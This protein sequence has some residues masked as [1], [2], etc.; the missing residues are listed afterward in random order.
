MSIKSNWSIESFRT[1][2]AIFI[3]C[4]EDLP[5]D[6]SGVLKSPII[7]VLLSISP[8]VYV[9]ICFTYS[10]APILCAYMLRSVISSSCIDPLIIIQCPSLSFFTVIVLM[11]ILSDMCV[12][13]PAFFSFPFA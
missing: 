5:I 13:I 2:V 4:L 8:F 3:F 7:I 6:V 9:S 1:F 10:G 12:A 11:S